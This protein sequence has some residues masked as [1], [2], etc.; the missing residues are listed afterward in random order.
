MDVEEEILENVGVDLIFDVV[1]GERV[2]RMCVIVE[3]G[4]F[5]LM[6]GMGEFEFVD[7]GEGFIYEVL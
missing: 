7:E 5:V 4:E 6:F 1:E 3:G 2:G